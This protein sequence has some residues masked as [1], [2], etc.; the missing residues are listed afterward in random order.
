MTMGDFVTKQ[1]SPRSCADQPCLNG[2]CIDLDVTETGRH[3]MCSCPPRPYFGPGCQFFN[4]CTTEPCLNGGQC[5][6]Y[7]NIMTVSQYTCNCTNGFT[8]QRCQEIADLCA[9]QPCQQ[10]GTC[11]QEGTVVT[12]QCPSGFTGLLCESDV[13]ECSSS[14]CQNG[15]TCS[16]E[17]GAFSCSCPPT[18]T[19]PHCELM[20]CLANPC[21]NDATCTADSVNG[22][23]C[24]CLLG[25][26]GPNCE[27]NIDDCASIPCQNNATCNDQIGGFSCDCSH[28][29]T[30]IQCDEEI[31]FC[32]SI[33]CTNSGTCTPTFGG[34]SCACTNGFTGQTCS[35]EIN[36]C[37]SSPC[38]DG[39][40]CVDLI[41]SFRC[42]CAAGF[43]GETCSVN[44]DDC[45][46]SP[47]LNGGTCE[48]RVNAFFCACPA[49]FSGS[50]C[51]QQ[52]DFCVDSPCLNGG[53]CSTV[54]TNFECSCT[55]DW[56][57]QRCQY[58][59]STSSKLLS[60]QLSATDLIS[61]S[62]AVSP[63][64]TIDTS[65][66]QLN[67]QDTLF[68]TAWVWQEKNNAGKVFAVTGSIEGAK[69]GVSFI[70]ATRRVVVAYSIPGNATEFV[71]FSANIQETMWHHFS[72]LLTSSGSISLFVD[73]TFISTQQIN[74]NIGSF[75]SSTVY[76]GRD[77]T[78]STSSFSGVLRAVSIATTT[79]TISPTTVTTCLLA[80]SD[81]TFCQ[82]NAQCLDFSSYEEYHCRCQHGY[83]GPRC[84]YQHSTYSLSGTGMVSFS[85]ST[86][87]LTS[88]ELQFKT[89]ES[90]GPLI[91]LIRQEG[92]S[93]IV[94]LMNDSL[95]LELTTACNTT[96]VLMV[97][98]APALRDLQWHS[99]K[100]SFSPSVT[101]QLDSQEQQTINTSCSQLPTI[102]QVTLGTIEP[103]QAF[104]GCV[105]GVA[106]NDQLSSAPDAQLTAPAQFG[107]TR[108]TAQFI[109]HSY[110]QLRNFSS[111]AST[112]ISLD[113]AT[114]ED[115]GL[116]YYG[117]R[118]PTE[119]TGTPL[120][121]IAIH[122][123][124]SSLAFSFNL[125]ENGA[126][127]MVTSN[128]AV[129]DGNWHHLEARQVGQTG[130][131]LVDGVEMTDM[132]SG[133]LSM[134]NTDTVFVG[135]VP[136]SVNGFPSYTGC[137]R[138]LEQNG[139][140]VDLQQHQAAVNVHFGT[141]N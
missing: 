127:V 116:I 65:I 46:N 57:G 89:E 67:N 18:H 20:T 117:R 62:V 33:P 138:D 51:E 78:T 77:E 11:T 17:L 115:N 133:V 70:A 56:L 63:T 79:T 96:H 26:T 47:C 130:T 124:N 61:E 137:I 93:A 134:L 109:G 72:L 118:T 10:G 99:L 34:F 105:R 37:D 44:I 28:G 2:D 36:E 3:Y 121:F 66:L 128:T 139:I 108:D 21:Q 50:L 95:S 52:V 84:Q 29:Y 135:G 111:P 129:N 76:L 87:S 45:S 126:G 25:T 31:N 43:T 1:C 12:C 122:I 131:L 30:G 38:A 73:G 40:T 125:G 140:A 41:N 49:G 68:F 113:F 101:V 94:K 85:Q 102:D 8:G 4:E 81:Q 27:I 104:T 141:C 103:D 83:T 98:S 42:D 114:L 39:S 100:V 74:F 80:C 69:L 59:T 23:R 107:C 120:D 92:S 22:H 24:T 48:D 64:Q 112:N 7:S 97:S 15:G 119:S 13:D 55:S 136:E 5:T 53:T 35:V 19:G 123:L 75:G 16:N 106:V 32:A 54:G 58:P 86:A 9:S 88:A 90:N 110:L 14:P 82:N 91:S 6:P 71:S 60:C 132:S